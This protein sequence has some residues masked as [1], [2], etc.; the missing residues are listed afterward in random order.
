MSD[1]KFRDLMRSPLEK[2]RRKQP[3][4]GWGRGGPLWA[5]V[6][7]MAIGAAAV[8]IGAAV[9]DNETDPQFS[10]VSTIGVDE[11]N[12]FGSLPPGY[13]SISDHIGA[14]PERVLLQQDAVFVSFSLAVRS[15]VDAARSAGYSGGRWQL[16]LADGSAV[17]DDGEFFD[18]LTPG[19]FSV[20][21]AAP[22]VTGN[23]LGS[24]RLLAAGLGLSTAHQTSLETPGGLPF[25]GPPQNPVQL[26]EGL[27]LVLD[28]V[29]LGLDGGSVA[30]HLEGPDEVRARLHG[31][32]ELYTEGRFFRP[33]AT[34]GDAQAGDSTGLFGQTTRLAPPEAEGSLLLSG[35]ELSDVIATALL[36][37]PASVA[38]A[39]LNLEIGWLSLVPA[40]STIDLEGVAVVSVAG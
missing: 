14:R 23:D 28:D 12:E 2:P 17:D 13:V 39:T 5:G 22:G 32:V 11:A 27:V 29:T 30:W 38:R 24:V 31:S 37:E 18:P 19:T 6:A 4:G 21:F 36:D 33:A 34:M 1:D 35:P 26:E 10:T 16:V 20:R 7:A 25:S 15:E 8:L 9:V 3:R 40:D